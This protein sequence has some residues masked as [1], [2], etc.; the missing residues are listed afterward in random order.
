[1]RK[2]RTLHARW[3]EQR[4]AGSMEGDGFMHQSL[5][6]LEVLPERQ[7][8]RRRLW[9]QQLKLASITV[10]K[11]RQSGGGLVTHIHPKPHGSCSL[12]D[13]NTLVVCLT[14]CVL[15][16]R[17]AGCRYWGFKAG[18]YQDEILN[19]NCILLEL[20]VQFA[21][22]IIICYCGHQFH[23]KKVFYNSDK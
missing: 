2:Q 18:T 22:I 13:S 12:L 20:A 7:G 10:S 5:S 1:M 8:S 11:G 21:E 3:D 19:I 14:I 16:W 6:G 15:K 4:P 9:F 23:P 17:K